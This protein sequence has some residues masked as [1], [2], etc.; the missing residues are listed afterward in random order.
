MVSTL[1]RPVNGQFSVRV[2]NLSEGDAWLQRRTRI[3]VIHEVAGIE[4]SCESRINFMRAT[5]SEERVILEENQPRQEEESNVK[6]QDIPCPVDLS[7]VE[8][9]QDQR[10]KLENL[11][12]HHASIFAADSNDLG[13]IETVKHRTVIMK[14]LSLNHADGFH[15]VKIKR[16]RITS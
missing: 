12:K 15:Q 13:Y 5:V 9:T 6:N 8:C 2:A 3:G 4:S 7:E 14:C 11:L 1:V 10:Q 16:S